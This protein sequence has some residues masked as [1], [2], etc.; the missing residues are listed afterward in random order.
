MNAPRNEL[1]AHWV[2]LL[3]PLGAAR[4]RAMFG[5]HGI[6]LDGVMFALVHED[7]LYLKVD[8]VTEARF[9]AAGLPRFVYAKKGGGTMSMSYRRAP[10][11]ALDDGDLLVEW[12]RLGVEASQRA[13]RS[14]AAAGL[15]GSR[16]K[17]GGRRG[18][19]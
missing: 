14:K 12:A 13:A 2:D 1:V 17:S 5:G 10:V 8:D 19:G 6:Y 18:D 15:R 16:G 3:Q 4:A 9:E 7:E 11:A